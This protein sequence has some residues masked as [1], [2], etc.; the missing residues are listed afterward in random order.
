M[1]LSKDQCLANIIV[2]PQVVLNREVRAYKGLPAEFQRGL[3][4]TKMFSI[5]KIDKH[6]T[7]NFKQLNILLGRHLEVL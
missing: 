4:M 2:F 5:F 3:Q 7:S 1:S 6:F